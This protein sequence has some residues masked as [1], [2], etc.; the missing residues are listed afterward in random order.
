MSGGG[1]RCPFGMKFLLEGP[2]SVTRLT[3]DDDS[4]ACYAFFQEGELPGVLSLCGTPMSQ[5]RGW[6]LLFLFLCSMPTAWS[7]AAC[8]RSRL[9]SRQ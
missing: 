7:W 1:L 6:H 2:L 4:P 5:T 8:L 3:C 9:P